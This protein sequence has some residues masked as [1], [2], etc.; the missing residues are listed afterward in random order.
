[1]LDLIDKGKVLSIDIDPQP[2]LPTHKR[3]TYL[4]TS[5]TSELALQT[6]KEILSPEH[7]VLVILDSDHSKQHVLNE[8]HLY[9][10]FVTLGS[11]LIVE[12]SNINGHPV[13]PEFGPGPM[14]A[15]EEFLKDNDDFIIDATKHKFLITF[16][17]NGYLKKVK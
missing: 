12:D 16:N 1:M 5:S 14:E 10:S 3:L 2:N 15:I 4:K 6:V 11:Y 17:P 13:V 7:T 9:H 8:L